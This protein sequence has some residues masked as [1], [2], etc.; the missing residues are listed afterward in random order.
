M[1][2]PLRGVRCLL[3]AD[4]AS[5]QRY[6]PFVRGGTARAIR[7]ERKGAIE[8]RTSARLNN[9]PGLEDTRSYDGAVLTRDRRRT[10]PWSWTGGQPEGDDLFDAPVRFGQ[11]KRWRLR[12]R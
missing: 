12:S 5:T 7:L 10:T 9:V 3:L 11:R 4:N 8:L 1:E 6:P 2:N